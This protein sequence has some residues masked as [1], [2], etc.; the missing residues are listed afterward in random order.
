M[1]VSTS[2]FFL[3]ILPL[4]MSRPTNHR[5][6][7]L[8]A[9]ANYCH[10]TQFSTKSLKQPFGL[11]Q[12]S[13]ALKKAIYLSINDSPKYGLTSLGTTQFVNDLPDLLSSS[14]APII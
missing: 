2:S 11:V 7:D 4:S 8:A 9:L 3:P 6:C 10:E 1:Q 12:I 5:L 13:F 14:C